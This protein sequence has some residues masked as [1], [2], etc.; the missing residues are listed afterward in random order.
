MTPPPAP[1]RERLSS[2]RLYLCTADRDDL[3]DFVSAVCAA[4]VDVVQLRD[5]SLDARP[6][7]ERAAV[8]REAAHALSLIHI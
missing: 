7:L 5:K 6:L 2:A 1:P 8:A 3:A 4:G